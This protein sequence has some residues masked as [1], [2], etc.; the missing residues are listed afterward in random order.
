MTRPHRAHLPPT[1]ACLGPALMGVGAWMSDGR[2]EALGGHEVCR[3]GGVGM[4]VDT[5]ESSGADEKR[6]AGRTRVRDA[7]RDGSSAQRAGGGPR[8]CTAHNTTCLGPR[9][10]H[11]MHLP[12]GDW[13]PGMRSQRSGQEVGTMMLGLLLPPQAD[14]LSHCFPAPDLLPAG[15]PGNEV[16]PV[17]LLSCIGSGVQYGS[18]P[19]PQRPPNS[20]DCGSAQPGYFLISS[21]L[22][23]SERRDVHSF[24]DPNETCMQ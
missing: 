23:S 5:W 12:G 18:A 3:H 4:L 10:W 17:P 20:V 2:T 14:V 9:T 16:Q 11:E 6:V 24:L 19:P 13:H 1:A 7:A 8:H 22:I 21:C 15:V